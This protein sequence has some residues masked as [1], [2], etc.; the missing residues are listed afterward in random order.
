MSSILTNNSAMVA[1]ETLRN[2]NSDLG[3]VQNQIATGKKI[4]SAQD[5]SAIWAVATTMESDISGFKQITD[6][7]NLGSASVGVARG[8]S[9]QITERLQDMKDLI[10]SAQGE[11]VD[12]EKFQTEIVALRDQITSIVGSAQFNGM[13]LIDGSASA[14]V[15]VLSS[16]DRDSNGNVTASSIS[17]ARNDLSVSN[18]GSAQTVGTGAN[19]G[20]EASISNN[21]GA[22]VAA[23]NNAAVQGVAGGNDAVISISGVTANLTYEIVLD[24]SDHA[25]SL[26]ERTFAYVASAS[27]SAEEVAATL[28]NQ[29]N[30]FFDATGESNYTVSFDG[31]DITISNGNASAGDELDVSM[32][33]FTGGTAG[34]QSGGLGNLA[35]I[36]VTTD[37][38]ATSALTAI[39]GLLDTA[40]DAAANFGSSQTRIDNQS[41]FV[42]TLMDSITSGIGALVDA[43]MEATSAKLQALQVQ[44]QLGTQAL[45]IA[46]Q[47]PQNLLSL[48]R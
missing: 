25:N 16:L 12:R 11:N 6:S 9:E 41:E 39:E 14:D 13:N 42:N 31:S 15:Q 47:A 21:G 24:D 23:A 40:I 48:F 18:T 43:D 2:I 46:N 34:V 30:T 38:G 8:A 5:N 3:G 4:S 32:R 19:A 1:L 17:V 33:T 20:A 29:I 35:N 22:A 44:Q 37:A 27:D 7:L 26:G 36:D 10:V 28:S 45:S